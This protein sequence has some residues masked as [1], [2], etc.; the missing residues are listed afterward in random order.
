MS[1]ANNDLAIPFG[2]NVSH[3]SSGRSDRS[4]A[5][6]PVLQ[7]SPH[8]NVYVLDENNN[9]QTL[10][11]EHGIIRDGNV[12]TFIADGNVINLADVV[13]DVANNVSNPSG[14]A[15]QPRPWRTLDGHDLMAIFPT[16]T[17]VADRDWPMDNCHSVFRRQIHEYLTGD[18]GDLRRDLHPSHQPVAGDPSE[19]SELSANATPR[20]APLRR[21]ESALVP[22]PPPPPPRQRR[23]SQPELLHGHAAYTRPPIAN[24]LHDAPADPTRRTDDEPALRLP[25]EPT[26]MR[27]V[28]PG[29]DA[30]ARPHA[31]ERP[32]AFAPPA[33]ALA[34]HHG[35]A[36]GPPHALAM[37]LHGHFP[38]AHHG[39]PGH[40]APP[41]ALPPPHVPQ[42]AAGGITLI[43]CNPQ[44][45]HPHNPPMTTAP[46]NLGAREGFARDYAGMPQ[47]DRR[48]LAH[49]EFVGTSTEEISAQMRDHEEEQEP[50]GPDGGPVAPSFP[51]PRQRAPKRVCGG[52]LCT[53]DN[54]RS[55]RH[56]RNPARAGRMPSSD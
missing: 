10:A 11:S 52:E 3:F 40:S 42:A 55:S 30:A 31:A 49:R 37:N 26:R 34:S 18:L 38:P 9:M 21:P 14:S 53:N 7:R 45:A 39:V 47:R 8:G 23:P 54:C 50:R 32:P 43:Q 16:R 2:S 20:R 17:S 46:L 35:H 48:R 36:E 29:L 22:P 41:H 13:L 5:R 44:N 33:H 24:T 27:P 25:A 51:I 6:D 15:R 12:H 56:P 28:S 19:R 4:N 1:S